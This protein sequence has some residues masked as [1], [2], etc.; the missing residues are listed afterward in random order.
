MKMSTNQVQI[1]A[2][3]TVIAILMYIMLF[4]LMAYLI[5]VTYNN[6]I[7]NMNEAYKPIDFQTA[8]WFT[9]FLSLIG[10]YVKSDCGHSWKRQFM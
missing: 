8:L 3:A 5:M 1:V 9:L 2:N 7:P 6:S 10:L 4:L